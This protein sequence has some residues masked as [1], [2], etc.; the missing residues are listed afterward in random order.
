ML[1]KFVGDACQNHD[2][3]LSRL[4]ALGFS[5]GANI[6]AT[7]LQC[8]PTLLAR[9]ILLRAMVVLDEPAAPASLQGKRIFLANGSFDPIVPADH[10]GR[11]AALLSAGGAEVSTLSVRPS[12]GLIREDLAAAQEFLH[13]TLR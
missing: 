9:A 6:A 13:G 1:A 12:H 11:L 7:L 2:V 4:I 10:P 5:N 8:H 3:E